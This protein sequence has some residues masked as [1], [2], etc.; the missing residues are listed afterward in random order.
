M[1]AR[2]LTHLTNALLLSASGMVSAHTLLPARAD[3]GFARRAGFMGIV[4]GS[5]ALAA[6]RE[7]RE[8]RLSSPMGLVWGGPA[9]WLSA[10]A[11]VAMLLAW[12]ANVVV[13]G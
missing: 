1:N 11:V 13:H 6:W 2:V 12:A 7:R 5:G 10:G 9:L 8:V 3:A 4:A